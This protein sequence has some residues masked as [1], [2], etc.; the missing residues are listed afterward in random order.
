MMSRAQELQE[1]NTLVR[2][3]PRIVVSS[4]MHKPAQT[5]GPGVASFTAVLAMFDISG[6]STL[7]SNLSD[8]AKD[9]IKHLSLTSMKIDEFEV[10]EEGDTVTPLDS[11]LSKLGD[12]DDGSSNIDAGDK[13]SQWEPSTVSSSSLKRISSTA[14]SN[15][16]VAQTI[17]V[18]SLTTT[19]NKSLQPIIDVI[20]RHSGDIIK[21]CRWRSLSR[22]SNRPLIDSCM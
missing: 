14:N 12:Y 5:N 18:D 17:A 11:A 2:H 16:T 13:S 6:F 1:L 20:L 7:G 22:C 19:L 21:V 8:T 9:Q 10:V 15:S 4:F 3:V